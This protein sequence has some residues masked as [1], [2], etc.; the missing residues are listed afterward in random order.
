MAEG[1]PEPRTRT[2]N[3]SPFPLKTFNII[4]PKEEHPYKREQ[5]LTHLQHRQKIES[6]DASLKIRDVRSNEQQYQQPL[7]QKGHP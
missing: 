7:T 3:E 6:R 1:A 5:N 2:G 4:K